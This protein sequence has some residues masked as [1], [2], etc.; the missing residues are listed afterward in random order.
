MGTA[1][2][3]QHLQFSY[4]LIDGT[5]LQGHG[6]AVTGV[7]AL[8]VREDET[9]PRTVSYAQQFAA[10][11]WSAEQIKQQ[12]ALIDALLDTATSPAAV[13]ALRQARE[14]LWHGRH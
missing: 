13:A 10:A 9:Q 2:E 3:G 7:E 5:P 8:L 4:Q 11:Q 6:A 12:L 1:L 14:S